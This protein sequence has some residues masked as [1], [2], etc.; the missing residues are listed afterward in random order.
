VKEIEVFE[1]KDWLKLTLLQPIPN[2][3]SKF[4]F[5][6][7]FGEKFCFIF[8]SALKSV[9]KYESDRETKKSQK[10]E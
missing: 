7:P 9:L 2:S 5:F 3:E 4:E 8:E 10:T 1:I 6:L